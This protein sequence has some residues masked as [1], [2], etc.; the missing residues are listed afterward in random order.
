MSDMEPSGSPIPT[1]FNQWETQIH[2]VGSAL[3]KLQKIEQLVHWCGTV[4][5]I[6]TL[7]AELEGLSNFYNLLVNTKTIVSS[8]SLGYYCI[9]PSEILLHIFRELDYVEVNRMAQ[10]CVLFRQM[11]EDDSIWER[12]CQRIETQKH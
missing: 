8:P 9:L 10:V 3:S 11:S 12:I 6:K 7:K 5:S 4:S 2:Q 1:S